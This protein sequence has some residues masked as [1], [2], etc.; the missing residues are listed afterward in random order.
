MRALV[1]HPAFLGDAVF[2][3]PAVRALK[4]RWPEG[5]VAVVA[6]PRGAPAAG[7]LPG[8][9]EVV[10]FDKRGADRGPAGLLRAARRLRGR[11]DLALVSHY[12]LRAGLLARLAAIPRRVGYAPFCSERLPLDR[13]RPFVERGLR[14][15]ARVGAP[16]DTALALRAPPEHAAYAG[17]VLAGA[18]RPVLGIVPGAEWE[19]KRWGAERFAALARAMGGTALVLG[20]P[21]DRELAGRI[22]ALAGGDVRDT[23]GNAVEEAVALLARCDAVVG[24]DTGLVHCARALGRPTAA[25][26]GPTA[27]ARHLAGPRDAFV[28]LGLECQPCHDHGP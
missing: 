1:V 26:F 13:S 18:A 10:V 2:L 5:R 27:A 16:G 3:G 15:A 7:L 28:S 17:R 25:I 21:A 14:L 20:G 6:T 22:A 24:G 23:T 19:T 11:F 8:C 4:A 12:G 9:D